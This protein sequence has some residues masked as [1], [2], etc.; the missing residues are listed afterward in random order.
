MGPL[1]ALP[2]SGAVARWPGTGSSTGTPADASA[3]AA[4]QARRSGPADRHPGPCTT[5]R[6]ARVLRRHDAEPDRRPR[7]RS[8]V[9]SAGREARR[10]HGTQAA[11]RAR[12][13]DRTADGGRRI[14]RPCDGCCSGRSPDV[15]HAVIP[16]GGPCQRQED[17]SAVH[18][19]PGRPWRS[20]SKEASLSWRQNP[21]T[22]CRD[23]PV[24]RPSQRPGELGAAG[25]G[26]TGMGPRAWPAVAA[27]TDARRTA[28]RGP[29]YLLP[30]SQNEREP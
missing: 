1:E 3:V 28:S 8:A 13:H 30:S 19:M 4:A 25:I 9:S 22:L 20:A 24:D 12:R 27:A 17:C 29:E 14:G 2:E 11:G 6:S 18:R 21:L 26:I 7:L 15:W 5:G 23:G 16:D 10:W